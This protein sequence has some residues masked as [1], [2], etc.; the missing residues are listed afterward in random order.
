MPIKNSLIAATALAHDISV[1]TLDRKDF[2]PAAVKL[3][4]PFA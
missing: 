1:V 4:A 3:V 2:E